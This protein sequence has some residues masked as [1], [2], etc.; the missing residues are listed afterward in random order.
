[1]RSLQSYITESI[2]ENKE[3]A[4]HLNNIDE[5]SVVNEGLLDWF[6]SLWQ[7]ITNKIDAYK[8]N[9]NNKDPQLKFNMNELKKT[10]EL[11]K[12]VTK[13]ISSELMEENS[14]FK[15]FS[16]LFTSKNKDKYLKESSYLTYTYDVSKGNPW[17]GNLNIPVCI[18]GWLNEQEHGSTNL[19][20]CVFEVSEYAKVQPKMFVQ[21][22]RQYCDTENMKGI[23][24]LTIDLGPNAT[25]IKAVSNAVTAYKKLGFVEGEDNTMTLT[26]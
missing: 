14:G 8:A 4:L 22:F 26:F 24:T 11:M 6:A 16:K 1:M 15:Q 17:I 12:K 9:N 13:S 3:A 21:A 18:I 2:S 19:K 10:N 7:K 20:I 23:E 5:P 25:N